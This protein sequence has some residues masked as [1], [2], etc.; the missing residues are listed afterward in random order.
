M[1]RALME[2][3]DLN[4]WL[5]ERSLSPRLHGRY[6]SFC[7]EHAPPHLDDIGFTQGLVT[8]LA[9]TTLLQP[10]GWVHAMVSETWQP[11]G[12]PATWP[13]PPGAPTKGSA[14][15]AS[16]TVSAARSAD[17]TRIVLRLTSSAEHPVRVQLVVD[18]D[19]NGAWTNATYVATVLS[20]PSLT[21]IN[22][23][24]TPMAVAPMKHPPASM[25]EPLEL[26]A[27]SFAVMVLDR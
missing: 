17:A 14:W 20:A 22:T 26:P 13:A 5:R 2:G 16:R 8:F 7:F 19:L 1:G 12:V 9:N 21:A 3:G 4:A 27:A 24:A 25:W 15:N 10:P 11:L 6:A 23:P 18:G